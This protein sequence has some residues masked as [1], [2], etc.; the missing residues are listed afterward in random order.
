MHYN[1]FDQNDT[2][3]HYNKF[4]NL[5]VYHA[6]FHN[7]KG[8]RAP[9]QNRKKIPVMLYLLSDNLYTSS[10][11]SASLLQGGTLVDSSSLEFSITKKGQF[12]QV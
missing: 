3:V 8:P 11:R 6:N 2:I 12:S 1:K 4:P 5:G 9:S 7:L 10:T